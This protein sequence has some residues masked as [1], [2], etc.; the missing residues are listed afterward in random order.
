MVALVNNVLNFWQFALSRE[1]GIFV[2]PLRFYHFHSEKCA[3]VMKGN[4]SRSYC[5]T[6]DNKR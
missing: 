2:L 1:P 5:L 3:L 4:G 6:M